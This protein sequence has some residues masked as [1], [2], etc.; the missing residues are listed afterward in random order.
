MEGMLVFGPQGGLCERY[1]IMTAKELRLDDLY[2]IVRLNAILYL[3]MY[4]LFA[5]LWV[6]KYLPERIIV[7]GPSDVTASIRAIA[8]FVMSAKFRRTF[9]T[10][11]RSDFKHLRRVHH[12]LPSDKF[13]G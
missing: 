3:H 10:Y 4:F 12:L 2:L 9:S 6:L 7:V 13:W 5:L 8:F 11:Y 1:D